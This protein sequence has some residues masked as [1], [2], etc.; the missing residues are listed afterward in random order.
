[1]DWATWSTSSL[2]LSKLDVLGDLPEV[3]IQ[4]LLLL[5][6][7][8]QSSQ[9]AP[10]EGAFHLVLDVHQLHQRLEERLLGHR[11]ASVLH[12]LELPPLG[13]LLVDS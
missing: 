6:L 8:V 9:V 11:G 5:D 3:L 12:L 2:T 13:Q 10:A 7:A 1:M 4:L